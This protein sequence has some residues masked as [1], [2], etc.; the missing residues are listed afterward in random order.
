MPRVQ[1][2]NTT[3]SKKNTKKHTSEHI[4]EQTSRQTSQE[5]PQQSSKNSS[6]IKAPS[7]TIPKKESWKKKVS[8]RKHKDPVLS[9]SLDTFDKEKQ[10]LI[11][12]SSKRSTEAQAEKIS[13][14]Q[15]RVDSE[16]S[17]LAQ[18]VLSVL[19]QPTKQCKRL[20]RCVE[21]G[22]AFHHAGLHHRQRELIETKFKE[23][24]IKIICSTPTLAAGIDLPAF[25]AIIKDYRRFGARGMMPIPVLE[26]EQMTGRAGRPGME[27]FG[28]A[29][30]LASSESEKDDLLERYIHGSVENIYSKLAVEPVL[31][32]YILSLVA[33]GIVRSE[34]DVFDFFDKTFYA[35]QFGDREKLHLILRRMIRHL[36]SWKMIVL[37]DS[38]GDEIDIE[39]KKK[40]QNSVKKS[41]N[42]SS[43]SSSLFQSAKEIFSRAKTETKLKGDFFLTPTLLGRRV[44]EMYL[45]PLT[46]DVLLRGLR[47]LSN[48]VSSHP[49]ADF[50]F[51]IIHLVT[52][53]LEMRPLLRAK[54][55]DN[56]LLSALEDEETLLS[57]EEFYEFQQDDFENTLKTSQF[58]LDWMNEFGEENIL[59]RYDVRP[60][61]IVYRQERAN[62]LLYACEELAR[63]DSL[64]PVIKYVKKIRTR[65]KHGVKEE[66]LP[67]LRFKGVGRVRARTLFDKGIRS[68]KDVEEIPFGMLVEIVGVKLA[69]SM[70]E[71]VGE[72]VSERDLENLVFLARKKHSAQT[73]LGEFSK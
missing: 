63:I 42:T 7:Q 54:R 46:A 19:P 8:L 12:C 10:A 2:K 43:S 41:T 36:L 62:W 39:Q 5:T 50:S 55:S 37:E 1:K 25:R 28:E 58:F 73:S 49:S 47:R 11:F 71:E 24:K 64:Q 20:A 9:L 21:K 34:K 32:T 13:R 15:K 65:V 56:D 22:V 30:L 4:S 53:S 60:G 44:S 45:D 38:N 35:F 29:I 31:R 48:K 52:C 66:L 33:T 16:L 14:A 70:K 61:E 68:T 27:D 72:H 40:Q 3:S 6:T 57:E 26:Y 23:R 67:L 18:E 51:P 17:L 59:D 69:Q